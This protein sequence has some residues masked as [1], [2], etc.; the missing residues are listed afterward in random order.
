[1][2]LSGKEIEKRIGN[3]IIITPF[4]KSK[5]NPNSYNLTLSSN[6]IC[7]NKKRLDAKEP[8]DYHSLEIPEEGLLLKPGWLYL[9]R[10]NEFTETH[11]LVPMLEGRSSLARLGLFVHISAGFGDVGFAGYWTL[12]LFCV[13]PIV[14]YPNIDIAQIYYHTIFGEYKEY[15]GKYQNNCGIQPSAMF[16][17]FE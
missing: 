2:I 14:I 4:D 13:Q 11:S 8:N 10:S 1:M 5:L 12:E 16:K 6:L 3:D 15:Q 9:G 7:Y 17:D